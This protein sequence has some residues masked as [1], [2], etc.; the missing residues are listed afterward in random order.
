MEDE[1]DDSEEWGTEELALPAPKATT[2]NVGDKPSLR[3]PN[4]DDDYW[5]QEQPCKQETLS[6]AS[7][8]PANTT[9]KDDRPMVIVDLTQMTNEK[10]H[11][12]FDRNSVNDIEAA[13]TLRKQIEQDYEHYAKDS[14]LLENGTVIPCGTSVWREAL[15]RLRDER[16]GHYF[17][18]IFPPK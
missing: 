15:S 2:A 9:I 6:K 11:S 4:N 10:I 17:A 8:V 1:S 13:S 3:S 12:K 18:P 14:A 16:L 5:A 7:T